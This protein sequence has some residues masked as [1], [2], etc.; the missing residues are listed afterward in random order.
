MART[1]AKGKKKTKEPCAHVAWRPVKIAPDIYR[2]CVS[3]GM[4][5]YQ[6]WFRNL[7]MRPTSPQVAIAIQATLWGGQR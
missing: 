3:C 6:P 5:D 4:K 7:S 1:K 2:Q